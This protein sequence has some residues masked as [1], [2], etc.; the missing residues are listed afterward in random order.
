M[1]ITEMAAPIDCNTVLDHVEHQTKE[2]QCNGYKNLVMDIN[3]FLCR[4]LQSAAEHEIQVETLVH[5]QIE[6]LKQSLFNDSSKNYDET[7]TEV[8]P[9]G[10][11]EETK[12]SR[13]KKRKATNP[14]DTSKAA[15][16]HRIRC[17]KK[18]DTRQIQVDTEVKEENIDI[19]IE[20][21]P[22]FQ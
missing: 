10:R 6:Q 11:L 14:R 12:C 2:I 17:S 7:L 16:Q 3:H 9:D 22:M 8:T 5:E 1:G 4:L 20:G 15:I 18:G 21:L 19:E 13:K